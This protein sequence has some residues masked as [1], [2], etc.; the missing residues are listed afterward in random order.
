MIHT[1]RTWLGVGIVGAV[2]QGFTGGGFFGGAS[3]L[4]GGAGAIIGGPIG[5]A[6][7]VGA[8]FLGRLANRGDSTEPVRVSIANIE[9]EAAIAFT[10]IAINQ[11]VGAR[12]SEDVRRVNGRLTRERNL[13][14]LDPFGGQFQ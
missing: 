7:G 5:A 6:L 8:G 10:V 2:I 3:A 14:G 12:G 9:P 1:G 11:V 13:D 4:L